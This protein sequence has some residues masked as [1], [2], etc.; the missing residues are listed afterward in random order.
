MHQ[1]VLVVAALVLAIS[2]GS[3]RAAE[4]VVIGAV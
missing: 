4:D 2:G 1:L 3:A